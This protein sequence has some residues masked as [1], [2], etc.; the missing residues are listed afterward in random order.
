VETRVAQES[1]PQAPLAV[2]MRGI[3]K[4]FPGVV[5]ND[6]ID[7]TVRQGE[8]HALLGENGAGKS[9]LMNIL[10]G[11]YAPDAG[12]ILIDGTP[13]HFHS[14]RNAV[15]AGLGMVHQ[16]FMLI[17]RFTVT[18]NVILGNE[19]S[20]ISLDRRAAER[21]VGETAERDGLRVDP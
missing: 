8:I 9:T 4:R 13:V 7:L 21:T 20:S 16:H 11:L 14:P 3:V 17:N 19:G 18:E 12:E 5:A 10:M 15:D 2:E 1:Q 6:G